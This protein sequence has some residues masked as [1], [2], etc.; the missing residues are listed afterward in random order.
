MFYLKDNHFK[1][2]DFR[3]LD[4]ILFVI[5]DFFGAVGGVF[6]GDDDDNRAYLSLSH[7]CALCQ[8]ALGIRLCCRV[9]DPK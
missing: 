8:S 6:D 3:V 7:A 9:L 4:E 1:N 5:Y 2:Y